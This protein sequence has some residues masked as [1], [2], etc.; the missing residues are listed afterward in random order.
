[1]S[2]SSLASHTPDGIIT[3]RF[4]ELNWFDA[5]PGMNEDPTSWVGLFNHDP[6]KGSNDPLEVAPTRTNPDGYY[7]TRVPFPRLDF[8]D[9]N[10]TDGCLGYWIGK[11]FV[12]V[13]YVVRHLLIIIKHY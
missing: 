6:A 7:R 13:F 10:L 5:P 11:Y 1:M 4:L 3:E 8:Y 9:N 2:V 12:V